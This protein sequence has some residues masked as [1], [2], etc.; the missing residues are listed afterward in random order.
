MLEN[1]PNKR[2][3]FVESATPHFKE[4]QWLTVERINY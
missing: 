1:K 2:A 3:G 4:K